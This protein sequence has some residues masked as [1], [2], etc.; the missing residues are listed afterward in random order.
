MH[1]LVLKPGVVLWSNVCRLPGVLV[2]QVPLM[3]TLESRMYRGCENDLR[4]W[5][6][7]AIPAHYAPPDP[8][9]RRDPTQEAVCRI[10]QFGFLRNKHRNRFLHSESCSNLLLKRLMQCCLL[11]RH[12]LCVSN[13]ALSSLT[14]SHLRRKPAARIARCNEHRKLPRAPSKRV[15]PRAQRLKCNSTERTTAFSPTQFEGPN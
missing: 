5:W 8:A 9:R 15:L 4:C 7:C 13:N 3:C 1:A 6:R 11:C 14:L 12:L 10:M 2:S